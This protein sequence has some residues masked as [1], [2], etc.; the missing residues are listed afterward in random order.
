MKDGRK[1]YELIDGM[2]ISSYQPHN[3]RNNH[4]KPMEI[5]HIDDF[6]AMSAQLEALNK[7]IDNLSIRNTAMCIQKVFCDSCGG[8]HFTKD[9]QNENL[10]YMPERL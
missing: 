8:E 3:E 5:C 6:T 4:M 10:F 9:C 1:R 7:K 2:V